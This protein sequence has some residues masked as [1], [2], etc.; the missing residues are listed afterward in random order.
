MKTT[1]AEKELIQGCIDGDEAK[2]KALFKQYY[3]PMMQICRR[4][5]SNSDE[6]KDLLQEGFIKIF[7]NLSK[8]NGQ[9]SLKTWMSRIQVNICIDHYHKIKKT[10]FNALTEQT[11]ATDEVSGVDNPLML[12]EPEKVLT[13]LQKLPQGYRTILNLYA[14]EGYSHKEIALSLGI[15]EGTSKSQLSK[16]RALLLQMVEPMLIAI[17]HE[18]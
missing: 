5:A 1:F 6:A 4:Y 12:L 8:F 10:P 17:E 7:Q 14:I 13:L 16:A 2:E 9:S 15:S 11:D 18:F 3:G